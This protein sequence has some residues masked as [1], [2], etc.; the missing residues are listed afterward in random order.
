MKTSIHLPGFLVHIVYR[1]QQFFIVASTEHF[2]DRHQLSFPC[3]VRLDAAGKS[4]FVSQILIQWQLFK[5]AFRHR[6]QVFGQIQQF[7]GFAFS[8]AFTDFNCVVFASRF[9]HANFYP[10]ELPA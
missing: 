7:I 10:T 8:L 2:A 1:V 4:H 3:S 6:D 5:H 9:V